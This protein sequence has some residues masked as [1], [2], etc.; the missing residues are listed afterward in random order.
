VARRGRKAGIKSAGSDYTR[1]RGDEREEKEI[2]EEREKR[3]SRESG[4]RCY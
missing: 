1:R 4:E 3:E 2:K